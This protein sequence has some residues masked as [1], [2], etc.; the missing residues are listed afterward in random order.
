[1]NTKPIHQ[2]FLKFYLINF[3]Q[4]FHEMTF[5]NL[6]IH[7][8]NLRLREIKKLVKDQVLCKW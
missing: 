6:A 7:L 1:M 3:S 4:Q 8:R 5:Y 2:E